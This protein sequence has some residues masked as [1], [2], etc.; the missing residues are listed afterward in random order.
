M[1]KRESVTAEIPKDRVSISSDGCWE[2][3]GSKDGNGY[4]ILNID[5]QRKYPHRL[6]YQL[7]VG[8]I[9]KWQ[10]IDHLCRNRGCINPNHLE[11]VTSRENS[12]RGNHPLFTLHRERKCKKGHDLSIEENRRYRKDGRY[13]CKICVRQYQRDRRERIKNEKHKSS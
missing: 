2:W 6:T 12:M 11:A 13:R 8:P 1:K 10:E 9:G 7:L 4:G 3:Q 5:G